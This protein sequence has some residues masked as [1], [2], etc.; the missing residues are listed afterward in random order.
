VPEQNKPNYSI[1][2]I[3]ISEVIMSQVYIHQRFIFTKPKEVI[4]MPKKGKGKKK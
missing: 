3:A 1:G 4:L 2:K